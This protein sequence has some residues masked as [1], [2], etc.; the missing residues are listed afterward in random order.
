MPSIFY[1]PAQ[2]ARMALAALGNVPVGLW[3]TAI[4]T[5]FAACSAPVAPSAA[6]AAAAHPDFWSMAQ[7]T[8]PAFV[9]ALGSFAYAVKTQVTS[10][11]V[12]QKAVA[13]ALHRRDT[14]Y[15]KAQKTVERLVA[16]VEELSEGEHRC[17]ES[18]LEAEHR[19]ERN[20]TELRGQ[21]DDVRQTLR[22]VRRGA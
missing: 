20:L 18:L 13:D 11:G 9:A 15:S 17:R 19:Y 21:L 8:V 5:T 4:L 7:T 1:T 12:A 10:A 16:R 2:T 22:D 6:G 14:E 3:I